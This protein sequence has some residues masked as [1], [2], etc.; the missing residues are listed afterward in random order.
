MGS[1]ESGAAIGNYVSFV[2]RD[3]GSNLFSILRFG[4]GTKDV[5]GWTGGCPTQTIG[6]K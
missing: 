5:C 6:E 1:G 2:D 4:K 3:V